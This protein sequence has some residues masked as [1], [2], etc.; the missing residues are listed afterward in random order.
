MIFHN[1]FVFEL[2]ISKL[3]ILNKQREID[4]LKFSYLFIICREDAKTQSLFLT[5][6]FLKF[7]YLLE[8]LKI[9]QRRHKGT[10]FIFNREVR[11]ELRKV[12]KVFHSVR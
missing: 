7:S 11:Q 8:V 5:A 1:Y 12:R 2:R 6:K 10:K 3:H 4:L 9:L